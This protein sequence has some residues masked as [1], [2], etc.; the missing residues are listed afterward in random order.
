MVSQ[1]TIKQ[2]EIYL[3][4]LKY[5]TANRLVESVEKDSVKEKIDFPVNAL[6]GFG[7]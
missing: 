7:S 4:H 6:L 3:R 5:W 2:Q 1:E